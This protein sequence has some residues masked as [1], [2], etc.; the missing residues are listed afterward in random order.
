MTSARAHRRRA[1]AMQRLQVRGGHSTTESI[2]KWQPAAAATRL[3][4]TRR[5]GSRIASAR[6]GVATRARSARRRRRAERKDD[7]ATASRRRRVV[8]GDGRQRDI[9]LR[10]IEYPSRERSS[11][12]RNGSRFSKLPREETFANAALNRVPLRA[13]SER[14]SRSWILPYVA[15][16][17]GVSYGE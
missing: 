1:K 10:Q 7:D 8:I 15:G 17:L 11:V 6:V 14:Q 5:R 12:F 4:S 3:S 16:T 2:E 13:R 9:D